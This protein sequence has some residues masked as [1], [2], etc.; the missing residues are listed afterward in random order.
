MITISDKAP[1]FDLQGALREDIRSYK[2][3]NYRNKWIVMFFYPLDFTFVC[4][5]EML[6]L[7]EHY[8]EFKK[9]GAEVFGISTDSVH[10]HIAWS[11]EL[12]SLNFPLLSDMH[13]RVA[14][15][16][17]ALDETAGTALRATFIIDP[18]GKVRW[19]NISSDDVG[20]SIPEILR[21][22]RA[23]QTGKTCP[24]NWQVGD[25]TLS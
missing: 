17:G 6:A 15:Q 24:A 22:L 23:L 12:G 20:R 10:S 16:Y 13:K 1:D 18:E 7:N 21:S 14:H 5:T 9:A 25:P 3:Q 19:L 11:K 4:P 8:E 2:L